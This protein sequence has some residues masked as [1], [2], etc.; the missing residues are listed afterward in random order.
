MAPRI[1]GHSSFVG[2]G[3]GFGRGP[4]RPGVMC[5]VPKIHNLQIPG[6]VLQREVDAEQEEVKECE[7]KQWAG[8]RWREAGEQGAARALIRAA[9]W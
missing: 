6:V 1:A 2:G 3:G 9:V 7:R 5:V 4:C 8:G